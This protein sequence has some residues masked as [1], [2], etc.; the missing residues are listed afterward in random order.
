MVTQPSGRG[1]ASARASSGRPAAVTSAG[2]A[3]STGCPVPPQAVEAARR[4][5][6]VFPCLPGDKRP[7]VDRWE[8]RACAD[9]DRVARFWPGPRH[10]I[11]VAC[12]PSGLVVIDLDTHGTLPDEWQAEP[13]IKDGR[14]VLA[15][16]AEWAGQ[17]WPSTHSVTTPSGGLHLYFAAIE[18]REIRNSASLIGPMIDVRGAGGYVVGPGSIVGGKPYLVLDDHAAAATC[19]PGSLAWCAPSRARR[20]ASATMPCTGPPAVALS[21]RTPTRR[22]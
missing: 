5:W 4:G 12:G 20:K 15:A 16:L 14:D 13:G 10:N 6:H 2:T 9:P 8:Q 22:P 21:W 3:A 1:S 17:P 18:G 7:A 19:P 11:G